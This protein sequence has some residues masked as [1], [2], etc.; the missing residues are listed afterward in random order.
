MRDFLWGIKMNLR[1]YI[2]QNHN[3]NLSDFGRTQGVNYQQVQRWLKY[4]CIMFEGVVYK[5]VIKAT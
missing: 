2:N 3:G 5:P 4:G 1:D